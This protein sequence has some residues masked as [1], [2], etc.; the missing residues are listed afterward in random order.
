VCTQNKTTQ[1]ELFTVIIVYKSED[2]PKKEKLVEQIKRK[3]IFWITQ[4]ELPS[5]DLEGKIVLENRGKILTEQNGL[6]GVVRSL[7]SNNWIETML[8]YKKRTSDRVPVFL[9]F[10]KFA[11]RDF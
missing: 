11:V 7:I 8:I 10:R 6:G 2:E 4:E 3:S 1:R 9:L 5:F